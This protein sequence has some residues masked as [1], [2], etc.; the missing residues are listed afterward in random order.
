MGLKLEVEPDIHLDNEVVIKIGLEVSSLGLP[1]T[2]GSGST[3]Y[4]VG[5]RNT[6][7]SLRLHD[8]ETQILAGLITDSDTSTV[9]KIPLLGQIPLLGHLFSNDNGNK[10]KTEIILS[11]TPHIVGNTKLAAAGEMEYWSGTESELRSNQI[12]L[13]PVGKVSMSSPGDGMHVPYAPPTAAIPTAAMQSAPTTL[14]ATPPAIPAAVAK[15]TPVIA[16]PASAVPAASASKTGMTSEAQVVALKWLGPNQAKVGDRITLSLNADSA[17]G[18]KTVGL[19]ISFDPDVLKAVDVNEGNA[20]KGNNAASTMTKNINQSGGN[21]SVE[22]SG[23]GL[24]GAS[25][26]VMITFEVTAVAQGTAVSVDS[27]NATGTNGEGIPLAT[28]ESH[29]IA[30]AQ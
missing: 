2:N 3:V 27:I 25:N 16:A 24:A 8:G 17:Q 10:A 28:P 23:A 29:V 18:L 30:V 12:L 19:E 6:A 20:L 1:V 4:R 22:M 14:L 21:V 15:T 9:D 26:I 11:I 5:T 7:T 13:R